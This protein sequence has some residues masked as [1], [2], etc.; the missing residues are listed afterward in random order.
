MLG[1]SSILRVSK[2]STRSDHRE[3]LVADFEARGWADK[4]EGKVVDVAP[5]TFNYVR[6]EAIGVCGQIIPWNFPL[7]MYVASMRFCS[8]AANKCAGGH[9]RLAQRLRRVTPL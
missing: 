9:G 1:L 3:R 4:I 6:K 5:D 7:L 2:R 8:L